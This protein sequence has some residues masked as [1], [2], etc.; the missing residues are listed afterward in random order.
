MESK[1]YSKQYN[2]EISYRNSRGMLIAFSV[3][4]FGLGIFYL[5]AIGYIVFTP[6]SFDSSDLYNAIWS[7]IGFSIWSPFILIFIAYLYP[8]IKEDEKGLHFKFL[9]R[10][11]DILWDEILYAKSPKPLGLSMSH[12]AILVLTKSR[13]TFFHR[14]YGLLYGKTSNPSFLISSKISNYS[15]ITKTISEKTKAN[16]CTNKQ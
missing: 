10:T 2:Y 12:N 5:V 1:R 11:Y 7:F 14:L 6:N 15:S 3:L 16:R 13:L 9:F 4:L 8:D